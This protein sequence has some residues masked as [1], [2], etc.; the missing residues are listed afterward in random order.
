MKVIQT[1]A[2]LNPGNSGGPLCNV[3]GEVIGVTSLKL[4]NDSIE[5]MGFAIKIEDAMK[6]VNDLENGKK[7]E[8]PLLGITH[9]NVTET[10]ILRQYNISID[11]SIN[12]GIAILEIMK[13]SSA[14]N[15]G[16]KKGD[17]IIAIDDDKVTN[18][19]YLRYLLYKHNIG[20]TIKVKYIRGKEEKT[21]NITLSKA[22]E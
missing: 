10:S 14:E 13:D 20:D 8:R 12:E 2:A 6:H 9:V 4:V 21:T 19:A 5:G 3:N 11:S 1:D 18:T 16:L 15:A 17:V 7:I 22:V